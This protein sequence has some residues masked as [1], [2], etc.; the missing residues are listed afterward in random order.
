[1]EAAIKP[2]RVS[3][4]QCRGTPYEVGRAQARLFAAT[5]KGHAFLR[6]KT[7]RLPWWF[8]IRTEQRAFTK[9]S[10]SIW[11]EIGGIA[12]ELG[13]SMERA[14]LCFGNDGLRPPIGAC[15]AIMTADAYGR[16]YDFK[17]RYYGARFVLMQ[18]SGSYGSIGSSELLTG[19]LDG[20]NEHGLIM[21]LHLVRRSPRYPGLSCVLIV[22]MVLDQ[23]STTGEA[24]AMLRRLPHAMQYNYSL[25]DTNGVGAVVEAVPGSVAVRTGSWLASPI[26]FSLHCCGR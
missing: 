4:V 2:F 26:I 20:M 5:P 12:D 11:E 24:I 21:G 9:F 25:L 3:V 10:R 22:R 8:N 13:I 14:V 16:N 18:A 19:R 7:I 1:M 6:R 17:P 15:S 23:C